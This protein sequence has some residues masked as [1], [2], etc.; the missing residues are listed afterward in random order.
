MREQKVDHPKGSMRS[1]LMGE[2]PP[3]PHG[4]VGWPW[5]DV[6][7]DLSPSMKDHKP[8]PRVTIVTPSY[9]QVNFIE[10]AIRSVLL[11]Y[12]PHIEYIVFDGG[13][14]DGSVAVIRK[15]A[16]HLTYWES[17]PD[18]GQ[19]HAINKGW[20]MATGRY[21]WWLNADDLL[22]PGSIAA[23]VGFLEDRPDVDLVYGD[24]VVID[25]QDR[26]LDRFLYQDFELELFIRDYQNVAQPGALL[27]RRALKRIGFLDEQLH[28]VMDREFW[29]RLALEGGKVAHVPKAL[30][31]Y[32]VHTE[33]KTQA[34]SPQAVQERYLCT[35]RALNHP[36][37]PPAIVQCKHLVWANTHN[38]C[39]RVYMKCGEYGSALREIGHALRLD[40]SQVFSLSTWSTALISLWGIILGRERAQALRVAV[41]R[42]RNFF[43][44]VYRWR[45]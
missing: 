19:S 44:G 35:A 21:L 37:I 30:A 43:R 4:N 5:A 20:R 2:I 13:S 42:I 23:S 33:A 39:A 26:V 7:Q 16:S 22:T 3:P 27:R 41:R 25:D 17:N 12:Y 6:N 11:Q 15:Y 14:T 45:L 1:L 28:Y 10:A 34:G 32:R 8:W 31:Y 36:N 40:P 18:M 9:N 24:L 38:V 29:L